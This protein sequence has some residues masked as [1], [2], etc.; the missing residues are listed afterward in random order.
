MKNRTLTKISRSILKGIQ[1]A[2]ILQSLCAPLLL[3]QKMEVPIK[4]QYPI[5]LKIMTYDRTLKARGDD[6]VTF[7]VLYEQHFR[8]SFNAMEEF[9]NTLSESP[10]N[11]IAGLPV[12]GVAI[13]LN[14]ETDLADELRSHHVDILY[15]A[16]LRAVQMKD[17]SSIT[18]AAKVLTVT[19]VTKYV[20]EGL[21][22]SVGVRGEKPQLLINLAA[23]RAEG[24]DFDSRLLELARIIQ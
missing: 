3:A 7:A 6:S 15:V 4:L 1:A 5:F 19:G 12:R 22:V 13:D 8:P 11:I 24:A 14:D 23:S 21:S 9:L 2:F 18:R 10:V 20:E 17:I 16:P